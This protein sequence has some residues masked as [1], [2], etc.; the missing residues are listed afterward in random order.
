MA[1][2][3]VNEAQAACAAGEQ[4]FTEPPMRA[5]CCHSFIIGY[6]LY[7]DYDDIIEIMAIIL[8]K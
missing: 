1:H 4:S 8:S 7:V 2:F 3:G 6:Y 5:I